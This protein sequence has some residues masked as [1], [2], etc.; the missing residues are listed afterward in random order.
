MDVCPDL[1][2]FGQTATVAPG[3]R[4]TTD[5]LQLPVH[6]GLSDADLR[7]V[8]DRLRRALRTDSPEHTAAAARIPR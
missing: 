4:R 7:R 8:V 2:L 5:A 6:A 1:P 3:A